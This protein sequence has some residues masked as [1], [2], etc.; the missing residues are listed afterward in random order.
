[1]AFF[2]RGDFLIDEGVAIV[3]LQRHLGE[4]CHLAFWPR[5]DFLARE[6]SRGPS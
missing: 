2:P 3:Y 5:E 1:L 6:P 4:A